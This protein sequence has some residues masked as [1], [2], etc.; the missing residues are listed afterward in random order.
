M[1]LIS[2][3]AVVGNVPMAVTNANEES[4]S[5]FWLTVCGIVCMVQETGYSHL[6]EKTSDSPHDRGDMV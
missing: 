4:K 6:V 3:S 5:L 2:M 1:T